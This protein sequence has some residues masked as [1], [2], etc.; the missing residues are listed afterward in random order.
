MGGCRDPAAIRVPSLVLKWRGIRPNLISPISNAPC[1]L[2]L[3]NL[4]RSNARGPCS[5]GPHC[6]TATTPSY[7]GVQHV[8]VPT[9]ARNMGGDMLG[10][11]RDRS[12]P[13]DRCVCDVVD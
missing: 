4:F 10:R 8:W 3:R 6:N 11:R 1:I 9:I 7:A 5:L 12:W 2:L 13:D